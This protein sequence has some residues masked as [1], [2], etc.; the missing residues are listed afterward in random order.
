MKALR[1]RLITGAVGGGLTSLLVLAAAGLVVLFA[2]FNTVHRR[3]TAEIVNG[4]PA[5]YRELITYWR[6]HGYVKHAGMWVRGAEEGW[7]PPKEGE[8]RYV[9]RSSMAHLAAAHA[10]QR[11]SFLVRGRY[12]DRLMAIHNQLVIWIGATLLGWLAMRLALPLVPHGGRALLLGFLVLVTYQT[13]PSNL[14][15]YWELYASGAVQLFAI[16]FLLSTH[17]LINGDARR[18]RAARA[19]AVFGVAWVDPSIALVFLPLALLVCVLM[20]Q[21]V[22]DRRLVP[23]VLAPAAAA[24]ALW[25][26]QVLWMKWQFPGVQLLGSGFF[27]RTGLDGSVE[28]VKGHWDIVAFTRFRYNA[29]LKWVGLLTIGALSLLVPLLRY[30]R[31]AALRQPMVLLVASACLYFPYAFIFS[32]GVIIHP[33]MFDTYVVIPLLL[34]LFCL[35]PATLE[36]ESRQGGLFV[37][38]AVIVAACLVMVQLRTYAMDFPLTIPT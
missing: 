1:D 33:T 15:H 30:H 19:I 34:S 11:V 32:Q 6:D 18:W 21:P 4:S 10:L 17:A 16:L 9:Y 38:I 23:T 20:G 26:A 5:R 36:H 28:Y 7:S 2:L 13:F 35:A 3:S 22:L 29:G 12:S 25:G 24:F 27:F 8:T 31:V 14:M 37:A